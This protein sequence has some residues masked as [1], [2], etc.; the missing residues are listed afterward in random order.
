MWHIHVKNAQKYWFRN[1]SEV[2]A[3]DVKNVC[4][5]C[6]KTVFWEFCML[7]LLKHLVHYK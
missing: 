5:D 6:F 7:M 2:T 1:F 4:T 3:V